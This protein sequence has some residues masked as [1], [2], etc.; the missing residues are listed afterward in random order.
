MPAPGQATADRIAGAGASIY[1]PPD[2]DSDL[3]YPV[4]T[5]E[6]RLRN[7][8]LGLQWDVPLRTRSKLGKMAV[9][10]ALGYTAPTNF[11]KTQP[12]FPH[13]N[14]D[15]F[16]QQ[17]NNLQIWNEEVD[18]ERRYAL[19][20]LD[21][22]NTVTGVR[23]VTGEA[24][25]LWDRTGTLTSK[26]QAARL[27]GRT[28]SKLVS[29]VDT[30]AF[31]NLLAPEVPSPASLSRLSPTERPQL[32][33]VL[34]ID[35]VHHRLLALVG[36]SFVD[37]GL[38]NERAR[39]VI[40]QKLATE[41]LGLGEYGDHGQFPD[42]LNQALEIKLQT[43]PTI[44][45]GLVSPDSDHFAAEIGEHVRH[46]DVRYSVFFGARTGTTVTVTAVVSATGAD[47]FTEFRRFEGLVSNRKLQIPLPS[48]LFQS[49]G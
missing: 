13:Q 5:L 27:E 40:L 2:L 30:I 47:F 33:M 26:Y 24:V 46:R 10:E 49:E 18:P 35:E 28:G 22:T 44:D 31:R 4:P 17:S 38:T 7:T 48:G 36:K 34:P 3:F 41:A 25:A 12:R 20:R 29:H 32:G 43:S 16:L 37:P 1:D 14:L 6:A 19:V 8:L 39:G 9:A 21:A 42:I 15:L 23:V 45:L 11:R